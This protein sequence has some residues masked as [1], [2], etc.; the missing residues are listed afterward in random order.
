M[1]TRQVYYHAVKRSIRLFRVSDARLIGEYMAYADITSIAI[2]DTAVPPVRRA[3]QVDASS[4]TDIPSQP[5]GIVL[6]AADG[7]LTVLIIS[8]PDVSVAS[9]VYTTVY[10]LYIQL[11]ILYTQL[12]IL[13]TQ[14]YILYTQLYILYTQLYILYTQLYILYTQL[15]ILFTQLYILYILYTTQTAIRSL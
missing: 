14:L 5:G 13:Y 12:Y 10:I 8:D 2:S 11:Y 7:T 1:S 3:S 15:Y 9:I 6:A 4:A